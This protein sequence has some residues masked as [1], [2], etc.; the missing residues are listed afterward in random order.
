MKDNEVRLSDFGES[1]MGNKS[2]STF[3]RGTPL[4]M[5]PELQSLDNDTK[6][7]ASPKHDIWSLGIILHQMFANSQHPFKI[8][9]SSD[10]WLK[11]VMVGK[12]FIDQKYILEDS[13]IAIVIRGNYCII[14]LVIPFNYK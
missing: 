10:S 2:K 12:Y 9:D 4:Y 14:V 5:P 3:K 11:N 13:Q 7:I 8:P 6:I 1:K